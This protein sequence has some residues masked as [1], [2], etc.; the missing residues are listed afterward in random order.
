MQ[1]KRQHNIVLNRYVRQKASENQVE[2]PW[3]VGSQFKKPPK[4]KPFFDSCTGILVHVP[5]VFSN[6]TPRSKQEYACTVRYGQNTHTFLP[7]FSRAAC[8]LASLP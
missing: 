8:D 3:Y 5:I 2:N 6:A 7:H 1:T 4:N